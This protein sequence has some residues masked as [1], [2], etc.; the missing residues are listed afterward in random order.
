MIPRLFRAAAAALLALA[1]IRARAQWEAETFSLQ[2]GWTA[3]YL[4]VDAS[5]DTIDH[6]VGS[7]SNNPIQEIWRWNSPNVAGQFVTSPETPSTPSSEWT[8]WSRGNPA[9]SSLTALT[10]NS[11]YLVRLKGGV[12][13]TYTWNLLGKPVPPSYQWKTTQ[14]NGVALNFVGFSTPA[15]APP[16]LSS[17]F[18][19]SGGINVGETVFLYQGGDLTNNP[20]SSADW[21][22]TALPLT[23]GQAQW[24]SFNQT[25]YAGPFA[26]ALSG[27]SGLDF[28]DSGRQLTFH[29]QNRS[30]ATLAINIQLIPSARDPLQGTNLTVPPLLLRG[31]INS[32][33]SLTYGYTDL[34]SGAN[35]PL[36]TLA[37]SGSPGADLQVV[38]GLNRFAMTNGNS[39][40][41][42]A[43]ILRLTDT[44]GLLQVDLPVSAVK[45]TTAGLWVGNATI[46]SVAPTVTNFYV[47]TLVNDASNVLSRLGLTNSPGQIPIVLQMAGLTNQLSFVTNQIVILTNYATNGTTYPVFTNV[48]YGAANYVQDLPALLGAYD[49]ALL[50]AF[51]SSTNADRVLTNYQVD[52]ASGR[53][54]ASV[55]NQSPYLAAPPVPQANSGVASP[56]TF[57]LIVHNDASGVAT[58]LQRVYIGADASSNS[59]VCTTQR[60][61]NSNLMVAARRISTA[62]LPYTD[63]NSGWTNSIGALQVGEPN[64]SF[65]V[66]L[67]F[68]DQESNPFLHT[69]HPDHDNLDPTFQTPLPQGQESYGI[70]R[71][72]VLSLAGN[73]TADFQSLT[74]AALSGAYHETIKLFGLRNAASDG[75]TTT[76]TGSY[77]IDGV[78]SLNRISTISTLTH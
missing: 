37:A 33:A 38:L 56:F 30:T 53:I 20:I 14:P 49:Q 73:P 26:V 50:A 75:S 69:Y 43:G 32:L 25:P 51:N 67:A 48:I 22:V 63:D 23:R 18:A 24:V 36:P 42:F 3:I 10:G 1:T 6:I 35:V 71:S 41:L 29:I 52:A 74:S 57:R 19:P 31:P 55:G 21:D 61:L 34:G 15:A 54:V 40:E 72:I 59:I 12:T 7:D 45:S 16:T 47:S 17:F 76:A 46:T 62:D 64:L 13:A 65:D 78:F 77:S 60:R 58:L 4:N 5:Y 66:S 11:A 39:G 8:T 68:D 2:P 27:S 44:A 9:G 70:E 28:G